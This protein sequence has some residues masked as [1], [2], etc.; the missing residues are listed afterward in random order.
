MAKGT[1]LQGWIDSITGVLGKQ[2][3]TVGREGG[4]SLNMTDNT[5]DGTVK[6]GVKKSP[7]RGGSSERH[8]VVKAYCTC[9]RLYK[10]LDAWRLW[11]LNLWFRTSQNR[12]VWTLA[13][14][15]TWIKVCR[16]AWQEKYFFVDYC[17][18]GRWELFNATAADYLNLPVTI[19]GLSASP[20][21]TSDIA[22]SMLDAKF[23]IAMILTV[24][25]V[26]A[27]SVTFVVPRLNRLSPM[28]IDIYW[29]YHQPTGWSW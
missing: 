19:S 27:N 11:R 1:V 5:P 22:V 4:L 28:A 20:R 15:Q 14:Y 8:A 10:M 2:D 24:T 3:R 23:R 17:W 18:W 7:T 25:D 13:A 26:G 29:I 21:D 16:T 9:D 6:L 12:N